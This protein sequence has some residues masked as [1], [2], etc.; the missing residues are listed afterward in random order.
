MQTQALIFMVAAG[1]SISGL[2]LC[3]F[4]R[5]LYARPKRVSDDSY[6]DQ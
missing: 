2:V 5:V 4:I 1:V 3:F 6:T